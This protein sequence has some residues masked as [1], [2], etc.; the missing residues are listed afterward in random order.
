MSRRISRRHFV[1]V[2]S[3]AATAAWCSSSSGFS[4]RSS[5]NQLNVAFIGVGNKGWDNVQQ[6][7]FENV[8]ALCDVDANYLGEAAKQFPKAAQFV[9][10]REMLDKLH[11]QIDAVVVSTPDHLHAPATAAALQ[12]GKHVYCEKPLSHTVVEARSLAQLA[13]R[14]RCVT[15]MGTQIHA[16]DKYRRVVELVRA[17]VIGTTER[18][19]T[20]CN[21]SWSGGRFE[22]V[23]EGPPAFLNWDLWQGPAQPRPFSGGL[24]PAGWR[25]FWEYGTGTFGD[26]ACHV[27]DLP[28]WALNLRSPKS[29]E[30]EGPEL[31]AVGTPQWVKATFEFEIEGRP[32]RL[33]WSD[34]GAHFDEIKALRDANDQPLSEWGLGICFVG[35][36]GALVADYGRWQLLPAK[37]FADFKP[38]EATIASS[39]GH[40]REWADACKSGGATTCN[41][42]YSG[43]LSEAVL[44]GTVAYRTREKLL[45]DAENVRVTNTTA[46]EPFL[47]KAYRQGWEVPEVLS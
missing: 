24:H 19:Y 31:D 5:L 3:A 40:W 36:K 21:K 15:Q 13:A 25:S 38:P 32:L 23:A 46:A 37:D 34:G 8:V 39:V 42:D 28:F 4:P 14:H 18:V 6:L 22:P 45:W 30:C 7:A 27:M 10:Y 17:N 20:W 33:F 41:F 11:T 12:L 9:D 29:V 44:L 43:R 47:R 2:A 26:M 35:S 16:G 1:Q